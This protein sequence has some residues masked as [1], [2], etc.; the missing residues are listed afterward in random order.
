MGNVSLEARL[1][2]AGKPSLRRGGLGQDLKG[3][4]VHAQGHSLIHSASSEDCGAL[5]WGLPQGV[6]VKG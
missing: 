3:V 1:I 4:A 6:E 5:G 2:V